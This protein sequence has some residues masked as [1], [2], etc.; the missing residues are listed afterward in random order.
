MTPEVDA[1]GG[2]RRGRLTT[3]EVDA[4]GGRLGVAAAAFPL[5]YHRHD[6]AVGDRKE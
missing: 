3:W 2:C 5:S 4:V 6:V 1:M